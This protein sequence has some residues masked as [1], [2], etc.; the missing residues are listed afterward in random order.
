MPKQGR[1]SVIVQMASSGKG[2][3]EKLEELAAKRAV[4][5][6][7]FVAQIYTYAVE[8]MGSFPNEIHDP[9]PKP[10]KHISSEVPEAVAN[11]LMEWARQQDRSRSGH[12]CFLLECVIS[13]KKLQEKI[14]N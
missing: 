3:K 13:D 1:K 4:S 2:L 5:V 6:S 8:N 14:F 11:K 9:L 12:C 10:G 7:K